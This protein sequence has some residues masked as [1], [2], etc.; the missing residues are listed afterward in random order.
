MKKNKFLTALLALAIALGL[1]FYVV[2]VVKP[3]TTNTYYNIPVVLDGERFLTE[4]NLMIIGGQDST[5]TMELY[6]NR[7]DLDKVNSGNITLIADLSKIYEPGEVELTYSHRFPGDV[8]SGALTVQSKSPSTVKLTV[9][10]RATTEV[11]VKLVLTGEAPDPSMYLVDEAEPEFDTNAIRITGPKDV[12]EQINHA[13]VVV[14][15]T[16]KTQTFKGEYRIMLCDA[17]GNGVDAQYV[18]VSQENVT[19]TLNVYRYKNV[20]LKIETIDGGGA[21]EATTKIDYSPE[22][23]KVYGDENALSKLPNIIVGK[24]ELSLVTEPT[25]KIYTIPLDEGFKNL[26]GVTEVEVSISFPG[27]DTKELSVTN[28]QVLN[29]PEGMSYELLT[30][31]QKITVRGPKDAVKKVS[32]NDLTVTIDLSGVDAVA[33]TR[34]YNLVVTVDATKHPKVGVIG[35]YSVGVTLKDGVAPASEEPLE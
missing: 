11:P 30:Q 24:V 19:V 32:A 26:S 25:T 27:L 9:V 10:E 12:I 33:G 21:T 35:T 6:G 4:R 7:I 28:I 14:D 23:I 20:P 29:V 2:T 5:V 13:A 34:T 8:P 31:A 1:W 15:L 17:E 16:G 18:G 22:T 3:D